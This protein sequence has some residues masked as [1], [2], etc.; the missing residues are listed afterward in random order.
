LCT[1]QYSRE[2]EFGNLADIL[3]LAIDE[4]HG[5]V[6]AA[7]GSHRSRISIFC[8]Q[9]NA[10]RGC[11]CNVFERPRDEHPRGCSLRGPVGDSRQALIRDA[12]L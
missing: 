7:R 10:A 5:G 8:R 11:D 3:L 6:V 4:D 12:K 9:R 2:K 1:T